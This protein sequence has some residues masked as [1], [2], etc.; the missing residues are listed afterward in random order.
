M[1][2]G[3]IVMLCDLSNTRLKV[4]ARRP[5]P[6][7]KEYLNLVS[8][9]NDVEGITKHIFKSTFGPLCHK[10]IMWF[11]WCISDLRSVSARMNARGYPCAKGY[12][13][14]ASQWLSGGKVKLCSGHP[15]VHFGTIVEGS[16][17]VGGGG[18]CT[19]GPPGSLTNVSA[20]CLS[21]WIFRWKTLC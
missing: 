14:S 21:S 17:G 9:L 1:K 2:I 8:V 13:S 4:P 16:W 5:S 20:L 19:M 7:S 10:T 6:S 11:K 12:N 15:K 18:G 3:Q